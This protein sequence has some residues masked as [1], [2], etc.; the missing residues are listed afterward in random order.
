MKTQKLDIFIMKM[1]GTDEQVGELKQNL[2]RTIPEVKESSL[3]PQNV[4]VNH[5]RFFMHMNGKPYENIV[6]YGN[7]RGRR[8]TK[9]VLN[10]IAFT[11]LEVVRP[12]VQS[13]LVGNQSIRVSVGAV[14]KNLEATVVTEIAHES[15]CIANEYCR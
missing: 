11:I 2:Q 6:L 3:D 14:G 8:Q 15:R 10:A 4:S 9:D 12:Y 1:P 7:L 13:L 5:D